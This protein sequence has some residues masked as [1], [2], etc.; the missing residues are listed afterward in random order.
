MA[1][2]T[3]SVAGAVSTYVITDVKGSTITVAV[4]QGIGAGITATFASSGTVRPDGQQYLA[5]FMQMVS[6]G[7]LP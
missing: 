7:L 3:K 4:T 1:S 5:N 6:T 2:M